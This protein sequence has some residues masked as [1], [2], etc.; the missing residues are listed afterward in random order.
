MSHSLC[1][2]EK[3]HEIKCVG[4]FKSISSMVPSRCEFKH[5]TRLAQNQARVTTRTLRV[6]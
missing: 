6:R 5:C 4:K 1:A 2:I 3:G